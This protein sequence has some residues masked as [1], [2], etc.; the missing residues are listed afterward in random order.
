MTFISGAMN[1]CEYISVFADKMTSSLQ[2]LGR[3]GKFPPDN[4]P[5]LTARISQEFLK[6]NEVKA[7][8]L[9]RFVT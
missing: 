6:K 7:I 5:K 8:D 1:V 2:K 4:D 9:A 3:K